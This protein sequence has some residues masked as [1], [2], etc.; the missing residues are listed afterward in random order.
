MRRITVLFLLICFAG[1]SS[2]QFNPPAGEE[3][4]FRLLSPWLLGSGTSTVSTDAPAAAAWNPAAAAGTQRTTFDLGY[5]AIYDTEYDEG[6]AGHSISLSS[7][8]PTKL[9][10]FTW[11]GNLLTSDY[12][13]L[14]IGTMFR[15]GGGF[16]KDVYEN[17]YVGGG[18]NLYMGS[19]DNFDYGVTLDAGFIHFLGKYQLLNDFRWGVTAKDFGLW[20]DPSDTYSAIPSPFTLQAGAAF[21][22]VKDNGFSLDVNSDVILP[23]MQSL[24]LNAGLKANVGKNLQIALSEALDFGDIFDGDFDSYRFIPSFGLRFSFQTDLSESKIMDFS[25]K[26]WEKS[27]IQPQFGVAPLAAG[28]WGIGAGVSMPLGI[29]D[30]SAPEIDIDLGDLPYNSAANEDGT[31]VSVLPSPILSLKESSKSYFLKPR[32]SGFTVQNSFDKDKSTTEKISPNTL[33]KIEG[34]IYLSPNNDGIKDELSFPFHLNDTRYI[35]GYALEIFDRSGNLVR[36]IGNKEE[37]PE[38]FSFKDMFSRIFR[39]KSG[40]PVP[41]SLRWDGTTE[42]GTVAEDGE[43]RFKV[44]AWDDNG[45]KSVSPEYVLVIDTRVPEIRVEEKAPL[46]LIFSP[47]DD[48]NKDTI[49]IKQEGTLEE[50]WKVSV[51]AHGGREV[52]NRKIADNEPGDF[53]WNGRGNNGDLVPDGIYTYSISAADRA[54]N[55]TSK[56]VDNIIIDTRPRPVTV[57]ISSAYFSPNNDSVQDT[58]TLTLGIPTPETLRQ[59]AVKI[60]DSSGNT[61]WETS[62]G[63]TAPSTIVFDGKGNNG[64]LL[65]EG[66]Y[67]AGI[68]AQYS[69]GNKPNSLSPEFTLDITPPRASITA[70]PL[71]FSPNGDGNRDNATITQDTSTEQEWISRI[72]DSRGAVIREFR[73]IETPDPEIVWNG[74]T[75][76]GDI[77]PDGDYTYILSSV[78]RAGNSFK[79]ESRPLRI[80][81]GE[82]VVAL[83]TDT[84]AFSPNGDSIKDSI[85]LKPQIKVAEGVESYTITILNAA[86]KEVKNY[87]GRGSLSGEYRWDGIGDDGERA[88]DGLYSARIKLVDR[89]GTGA[90]S[91]SQNFTLDRIAPA[92][93]ISA[94]Y[95][96]F[97]PNGDERKDQVSIIQSG[98]SEQLWTGEILNSAG[99]IV[100]SY[101]WK[102]APS[103]ILWH[104]RD[105]AGNIVPDA[106][107]SY[108]LSAVDPAGNST[109]LELEGI[110][111]DT[112]STGA[113]LTADESKISPNND[114]L[115]DRIVFYPI[116]TLKDGI[117]DWKLD[118]SDS[119][120]KKYA[121]FSGGSSIPEKIEWNGA[122]TNGYV[123]DGMYTPR[124]T[125]NYLKGDQTLAELKP[126]RVDA[127]TPMVN[128]GA[129]PLPFSP[130]NDGLDDELTF[131]I[132]VQDLSPIKDW[133]LEIFDRQMN[134]FTSFGGEGTPKNKIIWDGRSNSG[135]LVIAAEDYPFRF[136]I[137]DDLGNVNTVNGTLPIDVLVIRDGDKLKIQIAAIVFE[138]NSASYSQRDS[139]TVEKN[140]FVL[141]RI[142]EILNK[143]RNYRITVEGHANPVY[144]N[145]PVRGPTEEKNELKPLSQARAAAVRDSLIERGINPGRLQV[146]GLGGTRNIA[147]P[148]DRDVNWKNRR[149]EFIL[150]K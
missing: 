69:N 91:V 72:V 125:V 135:E 48:G 96:L 45:N 4:Y 85:L 76:K 23:S 121:E 95:L 60:I 83:F 87:S 54:G 35:K 26:G 46:D 82:T 78:D 106:K 99:K 149:V 90:E 58:V 66:V 103:A 52:F 136:T 130:D 123:K 70:S 34:A 9:G 129:S 94:D 33:Q 107:Y 128:I 27:D 142:A 8:L 114:G 108:R 43:Y 67:R 30:T 68:E 105:E 18:L 118:V 20:Y 146:T 115:Y 71:I 111:V 134:T 16:A 97:S 93:E 57:N 19:N 47:N 141:N 137:M 13:G 98:S 51:A 21:T 3:S 42:E 7:S 73:W 145:D 53:T 116:V 124:L 86:G 41:E 122:D 14:D 74:T 81:T 132:D 32:K 100:R 133:K 11:S 65:K 148:G 64:T 84:D 147:D 127:T 63:T 49:Q 126:I 140:I 1:I 92:A 88:V 17:L 113:Y 37:R 79:I 10:V 101:R 150:E 143:Y 77:A 12:E 75:G 2:A 102:G 55:I 109:I 6:I 138:P 39:S 119:S 110:T 80:S 38:S 36:T 120:G 59:W 112:R 56:S 104:G 15:A 61:Q 144:F 25:K 89:N 131:T 22:P 24:R 50:F 29:I 117:S 5:V 44:S 40:I 31:P 62:G 139:Q 28:A